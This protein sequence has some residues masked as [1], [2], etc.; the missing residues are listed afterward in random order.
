[1]QY[2]ESVTCIRGSGDCGAVV[3]VSKKAEKQKGSFRLLSLALVDSFVGVLPW[4]I[5][6]N[7]RLCPVLR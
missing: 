2:S 6:G 1:M 5:P 7:D 4:N 3:L